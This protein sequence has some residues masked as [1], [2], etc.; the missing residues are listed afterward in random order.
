LSQEGALFPHLSVSGN[1]GYGLD[2]PARRSGRIDE[3]LAV[4]G[5]DGYQHRMPHQLSGG[6][7]QRVTLARAPAPHPRLILLDEQ[8]LVQAYP[9]AAGGPLGE[10]AVR[11]RPAHAEHRAGQ[12]P[13]GAAGL[14]QVDDRG[15]DRPIIGPAT[16]AALMAAR[17]GGDQR[18]RDVPQIVR[19]P[20]TD[21]VFDH[22]SE[23]M[24]QT[25]D[26]PNETRPK[27]A[28]RRTPPRSEAADN[29]QSTLHGSS[30][31]ACTCRCRFMS[32]LARRGRVRRGVAGCGRRRSGVVRSR[33]PSR[34]RWR[35]R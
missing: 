22:E 14:G 28:C 31:F 5:L 19:R 7:Q 17:R 11:G 26:H 2:R 29:A 23:I 6:Q 9:Q 33:G 30:L 1:V 10:P 24:P 4:G 3:V 21:H 35:R 8:L 25:N 34:V 15:Q 13:P 18:F 32:W 16:P 20:G 12:F 27:P